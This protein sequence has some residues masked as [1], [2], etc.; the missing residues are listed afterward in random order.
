MKKIVIYVLCFILLFSG[1]KNETQL[2]VTP[3]T[4]NSGDEKQPTLMYPPIDP[5]DYVE[6]T[7]FILEPEADYVLVDNISFRRG[8]NIDGEIL[9]IGEALEKITVKDEGDAYSQLIFILKEEN[10]K[11]LY[12]ISSELIQ[13]GEKISCWIGNEQIFAAEFSHPIIDGTFSVEG[14]PFQLDKCVAYFH[15]FYGISEGKNAQ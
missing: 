4:S 14:Q 1:C 7:P 11:L 12:Q 10:H 3:G 6:P 8:E 15:Q 2:N 13:S 5:P 9:F